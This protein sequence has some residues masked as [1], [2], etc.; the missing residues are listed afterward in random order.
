MYRGKGKKVRVIGDYQS[1]SGNE[2]NEDENE[3]DADPLKVRV[4]SEEKASEASRKDA[5]TPKSSK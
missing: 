3:S 2:Y 5:S 4:K 1:D